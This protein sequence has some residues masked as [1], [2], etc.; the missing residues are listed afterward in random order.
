MSF[1]AATPTASLSHAQKSWKT[2]LSWALPLVAAAYAGSLGY[3]YHAM[4]QP[5]E[6]FGRV[7]MH[8]GPVPFLLFPFE[9]MWTHARAGMLTVGS[10]AP[11]FELPCLDGSGPVRLSAFQGAKPVILIFGSY[12]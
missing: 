7:M 12:T 8:T 10:Q 9:T 1:D 11:D 3:F 2:W 5:P 4:R 6:A